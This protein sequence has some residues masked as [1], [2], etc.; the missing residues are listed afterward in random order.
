MGGDVD[1]CL[2]LDGGRPS[3]PGENAMIIARDLEDDREGLGGRKPQ[4]DIKVCAGSR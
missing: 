4:S 1:S 3:C 2:T